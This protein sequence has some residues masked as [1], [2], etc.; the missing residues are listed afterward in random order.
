[1]M[2]E[3]DS[4]GSFSSVG[5]DG[6]IRDDQG[7]SSMEDSEQVSGRNSES[8]TQSSSSQPACKDV[9][10]AQQQ[11][12]QQQSLLQ[13]LQ[14]ENEALRLERDE[15]LAKVDET[16][17]GS[18]AALRFHIQRLTTQNSKLQSALM[19]AGRNNESEATSHRQPK[20]ESE[21]ESSHTQQP[22]VQDVTVVQSQEEEEEGVPQQPQHSEFSEYEV[23][24]LKLT[25]DK[26]KGCMENLEHE[27]QRLV[28]E[29]IVRHATIS[30][31]QEELELKD[32][33]IH[34]LQSILK[35]NNKPKPKQ[36]T[37]SSFFSSSSPRSSTS[38]STST[39]N[40]KNTLRSNGSSTMTK[41]KLP[42]GEKQQNNNNNYI[43][44]ENT[45]T[46]VDALYNQNLKDSRVID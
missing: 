29:G 16:D 2:E 32:T 20:V 43:N 18:N 21:S 6:I 27:L 35:S 45:T 22:Q 11:Q 7:Q 25:M 13:A 37:T 9:A 40:T 15:A 28:Q 38:T 44:K 46:T 4:S 42:W 19:W 30:S 26:M 24:A 36:T 3:D 14:Q 23:E 10:S 33:K 34:M 17:D 5:V 31:L 39:T 8:K 1:M 12:P 41:W